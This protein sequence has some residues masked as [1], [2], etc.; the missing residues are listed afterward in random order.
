MLTCYACERRFET[1]QRCD[2]GEPLWVDTDPAGIAWPDRDGVWAFGDLLP[3]ERP[4]DGL[5]AAAGGTPLVRTPALDVDGARVHVKLEGTNP[6]G[7]FKDRGSAVGVAAAVAAGTDT[8][9]TVSH[10]N[11][12]ASM[13][14]HA[15]GADLDC[16]VLVPA[17]IPE[18]RLGRIATY[19]PRIVRVDGDY[20]RLYH[21]ALALAPAAGVEFVVSD[22]PLRVAGQ[23]T[24][25]LE[26]LRAFA[27]GEASGAGDGAAP[28]P[29]V[30][31]AVVL[32]VSSGGHASAAWKAVREASAAGL[33]DDPPRLYFVQ[34][35]ACA[36]VAR[37][38]ERG[39]EAVTR[40]APEEVGETVAYSIAN[41]DPPSGT[42]AL[43]AARD[44]GGA[45]LAVDDD[46]IRDAQRDLAGAGLR[47]EA[48]SATPLA[49]VRTLRERGAVDR[50][51]HVVCVATGVGYG[52]GSTAVDAETV[53]RADLGAA[54]GVE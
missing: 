1:G 18:A 4:P 3:V 32:P 25:T 19:G 22:S 13:A 45:V 16:V 33:L 38:F 53:A 43:A 15:A 20:G 12:A 7:S 24:T 23:K 17:D 29:S 39:D 27:A 2:C 36:P 14:A 48:A 35:A 28:S 5:A 40:L 41:A 49:A 46:A 50:G 6:T 54:L 44:T 8:V 37:A 47:V 10:G 30:P 52:S 9:G 31:D 42:R 34:A 21:D 26:V 11:M 51:E